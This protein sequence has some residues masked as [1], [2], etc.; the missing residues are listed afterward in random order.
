MSANTNPRPVMVTP[1]WASGP[2][3]QLGNRAG[4]AGTM[5]VSLLAAASTSRPVSA[6]SAARL[7]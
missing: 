6:S 1:L 2:A 3:T 4:L 7:P 5:K